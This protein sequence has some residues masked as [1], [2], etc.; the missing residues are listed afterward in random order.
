[1]LPFYFW[2]LA[3]ITLL[4]KEHMSAVVTE[5]TAAAAVTAVDIAAE[6][7]LSLFTSGF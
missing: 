4:Q 6:A 5:M 2:I 3:H 7:S 1:M